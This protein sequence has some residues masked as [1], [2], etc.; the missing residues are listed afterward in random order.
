MHPTRRGGRRVEVV[1]GIHFAMVNEPY[2]DILAEAVE[3]VHR[4]RRGGLGVG[5]SSGG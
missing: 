5:G 3:G 2:V 4:R 1:S